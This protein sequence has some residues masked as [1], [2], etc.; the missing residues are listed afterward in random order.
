VEG[1]NFVLHYQFDCN[2]KVKEIL[3]NVPK[4][5]PVV[6]SILDVFPCAGFLYE[7]EIHDLFG[8][9]FEGNPK[10]HDKL[11]LAEKWKGRHPMRK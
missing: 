5:N 1:K 10:L 2:G 6:E 4:S 9:E 7:R 3:V 11:F 8:V